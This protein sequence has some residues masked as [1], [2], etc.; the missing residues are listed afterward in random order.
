MKTGSVS[1]ELPKS[2]KSRAKPKTNSMPYKAF[3]LFPSEICYVD[4]KTLEPHNTCVFKSIFY[5]KHGKKARVV[6]IPDPFFALHQRRDC[7]ENFN[8]VGLK[9]FCRLPPWGI[10][11]MRSFELMTSIQKMVFSSL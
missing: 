6:M 3:K 10:D 8:L 5:N 11:I 1:I 7:K 4:V 9:D 2:M